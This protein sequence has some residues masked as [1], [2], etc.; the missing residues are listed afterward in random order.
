MSEH[1]IRDIMKELKDNWAFMFGFI[2]V[3]CLLSFTIGRCGDNCKHQWVKTSET[4][5]PSAFEQFITARTAEMDTEE[6]TRKVVDEKGLLEK[7]DPGFSRNYKKKLVIIMT[8]QK[9]GKIE[10]ITE[11]NP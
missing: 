10:T 6:P 11:V 8:C 2:F 7:F 3:F 9:C 5:M 1:Y 4:M